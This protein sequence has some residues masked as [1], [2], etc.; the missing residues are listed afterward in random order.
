MVKTAYDLATAYDM[1]RKELVFCDVKD[2]VRKVAREFRE[3]S[4]GSMIVVSRNKHMGIVSDETLFRA[5]ESGVDL[6]S[7][8]VGDL[9]LDPIHTV[10]KDASLTEVARL[11]EETG[12]SRLGVVDECGRIV[13]LVKK[14]N[15][16]LLD[17]FSFVDRA[18][19]R[20]PGD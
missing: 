1:G 16:E 5:I 12:A 17:R 14:R 9:K 2:S 4:I 11:F 15:L 7:A 18:L 6:L 8:R 10:P 13:A 20:A 3:R 19:Q